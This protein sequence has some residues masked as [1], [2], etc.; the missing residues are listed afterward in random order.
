MQ[1]A[2]NST[3][4]LKL[5]WMKAYNNDEMIIFKNDMDYSVKSV[6]NGLLLKWKQC[7]E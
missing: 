6:S 7:I 1:Y 3:L 2:A 4:Y 5:A